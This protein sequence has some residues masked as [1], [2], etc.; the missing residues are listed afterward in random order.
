[1][2]KLYI[3]ALVMMAG[4]L[5]ALIPPAIADGAVSTPPAC[6][7]QSQW[8]LVYDHTNAPSS[9]APANVIVRVEYLSTN[10]TV[11]DSEDIRLDG[12]DLTSYITAQVSPATGEDSGWGTGRK[13][14]Y[15]KS[16]WLI[17]NAKLTKCPSCTV[18]G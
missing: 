9:G 8:K 15:R 14:K 5:P 4:I 3:L 2:M 16:K 7:Q 10:G 13:L 12:A 17:D 18:V 1:M 6:E 11:L